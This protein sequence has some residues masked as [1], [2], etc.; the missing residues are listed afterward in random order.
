MRI[1]YYISPPPPYCVRPRVIEHGHACEL[2]T[3]PHR[4]HHE[5]SL[6]I[7]FI[8]LPMMIC[9]DQILWGALIDSLSQLCF[10]LLT[11]KFLPLCL[12]CSHTSYHHYQQIT[13]IK[14][15]F[16]MKFL[17]FMQ[18]FFVSKMCT[19]W[20]ASVRVCMC[21]FKTGLPIEN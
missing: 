9:M 14:L 10:G 2:L 8:S 6:P 12:C 3:S 18:N 1:F 21:A 15:Y 17:T 7:T 11:A 19:C 13:L 16:K 20:C 4:I 5:F